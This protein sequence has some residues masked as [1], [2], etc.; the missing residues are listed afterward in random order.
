MPHHHA[1]LV[2]HPGGPETLTYTQ[3]PAGGSIAGLSADQTPRSKPSLKAGRCVVI[4]LLAPKS[5][6]D[7]GT[8]ADKQR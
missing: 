5:D 1:I 8:R 4:V 6:Q 2:N 7:N 3:V